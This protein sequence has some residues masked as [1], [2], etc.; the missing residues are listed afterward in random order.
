MTAISGTMDG[1]VAALSSIGILD[2][3][4]HALMMGTVTGIHM[5]DDRLWN[6]AELTYSGMGDFHAGTGRE[7]GYF[8]NKHRNGDISFGRYEADV[9]GSEAEMRAAGTWTLISGTGQLA[10]VRGGGKFEASISKT[11]AVTMRWSGEYELNR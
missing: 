4:L 11:Q 10:N 1:S 3:P 5:S 7:T 9:T 8:R 2:E 6:G